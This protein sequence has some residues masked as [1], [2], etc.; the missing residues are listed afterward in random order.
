M[1][2][3]TPLRVYF[4]TILLS[5]NISLIYCLNHSSLLI[6]NFTTSCFIILAIFINMYRSYN[7]LHTFYQLMHKIM[8]LLSIMLFHLQL[9]ITVTRFLFFPCHIY[10]YSKQYFVAHPAFMYFLLYYIVLFAF[11]TSLCRSS[12]NKVKKPSKTRTRTEL[13]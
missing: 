8:L 5:Q 1:G 7:A 3:L 6:C 2:Y 13:S 4:A 10:I 9:K 11:I 12:I